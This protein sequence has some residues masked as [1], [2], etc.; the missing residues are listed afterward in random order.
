MFSDRFKT[1][2]SISD[3]GIGLYKSLSEKVNSNQFYEKFNLLEKLSNDFPLKVDDEIKKS[4]LILFETLFYSMLKDRQ[5]LFDLMCNVVI[6]CGGYFRLH[7]DNAQ[8]IV[9]ARMLNELSLLNDIRKE[10]LKLHNKN[11]FEIIDKKNFLEEMLVL[12]EKSKIQIIVLAHSI[13][14]KYSEDTRFS[15]IRLFEVKF[16]GVHIEVEIPNLNGVV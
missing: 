3:N 4:V 16:K 12:V 14:K 6:N 1:K 11:F 9:S 10:I 7:T 5:G 15:S 2:F 13:L 8:I